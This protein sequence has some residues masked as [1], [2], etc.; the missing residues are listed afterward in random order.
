MPDDTEFPDEWEEW[1]HGI[2]DGGTIPYEGILFIE[3]NFPEWVNATEFLGLSPD[4]AALGIDQGYDSPED[5]GS[6][7]IHAEGDNWWIELD[8]NEFVVTPDNIST[9][10]DWWE[11][12]EYYD[13]DVDKDIDT[14]DEP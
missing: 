7:T 9:V 6:I 11:L 4:T 14:G 10:W 5:I 13:I 8:G 3:D 1:I 2:Q 12:G